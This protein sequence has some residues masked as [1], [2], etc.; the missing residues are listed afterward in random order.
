MLLPESK[1]H[2]SFSYL[3]AGLIAILLLLV[4]YIVSG[5]YFSLDEPNLLWEIK[6]NLSSTAF[7]VK[8]LQEGR[9]LDGLFTIALQTLA[10][11]LENLKY[12]RILS[13]GLLFT[14]CVQAGRYFLKKG[15][16]PS[17]VYLIGLMVFCLPGFSVYMC[18]AECASL[19]F[20]VIVSFYAGTLAMRALEK[21]LNKPPLETSRHWFY[22]IAAG[23]LQLVSLCD[24]Q[25]LALVFVVP[26]FFAILMHPEVPARNKVWFLACF[27][28]TFFV[29]ILA[30]LKLYAFILDAYH[31]QMVERGTLSL[32]PLEKILWYKNILLE[33]SRLHLLLLKP[34]FLSGIFSLIL[35]I[36]FII[37]VYKKRFSDLIFLFIFCTLV[38]F[39]HLLIKDSWGASRNFGL[40]GF[41]LIIYISIRVRNWLS[42]RSGLM[43]GLLTMIFF[44]I[45][46]LNIREG[47]TRPQEEDYTVLKDFIKKLPPPGN[48]DLNIEVRLPEWDMHS[49]RSVLKSYYDE[50]NDPVFLRR[51]A[52][53]P[54]I[55]VLYLE[56]YPEAS[57]GLIEKY[58]KIKILETSEPFSSSEDSSHFNLNL[59][60]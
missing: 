31:I 60:Y 8:Y 32:H 47:W 46:V 10:G 40:I 57:T 15:L 1:S 13:V 6:K 25:S 59:N 19:L 29:I 58:F 36:L 42:L 35:L 33:A 7:R 39:P 28:F 49:K 21:H 37:D 34:V 52:I 4:A 16:E 38:F 26:A 50:Y 22:L 17:N 11:T 48:K 51:W 3:F 9:P 24:Y 44:G 2:F 12:L 27:V 55:K 18:W 54:G 43:T 45:L 56:R 14:F 41:L 53:D 5:N 30:Y 20:S 23:L